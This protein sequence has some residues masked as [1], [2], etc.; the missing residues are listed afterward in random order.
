[1][2]KIIVLVIFTFA[3]Q[4]IYVYSDEGPTDNRGGHYD[5]ITGEYH[6]H[7][8]PKKEISSTMKEIHGQAMDDARIHA[9]TISTNNWTIGGVLLGIF[10]IGAAYMITPEIPAKYLLG[11]PPDYVLIYTDTYKDLI[12]TKRVNSATHGCLI[13]AGIVTILY[14]YGDEL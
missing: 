4:N 2:R 8:I 5:R 1:M 6:R 10:A 14:Y 13:G 11:K 7:D 3:L 12:R 9:S